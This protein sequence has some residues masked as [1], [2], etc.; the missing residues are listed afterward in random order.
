MKIAISGKRDI[1]EE[2]RWVIGKTLTEILTSRNDVEAIIFGGARGTDTVALECAYKI[3]QEL[4]MTFELVVVV[5]FK[6]DKQPR[7]AR[8]AIERYADRVIELNLPLSKGGY[9]KRNEEIVKMADLIIAFW[10][11]KDGGTWHTIKTAR[12]F[13]KE[14]KI[15]DVL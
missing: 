14:I 6:V 2:A 11:R 4:N 9:F 13:G 5:P 7:E 8:E 12:K 10:D 15:V 1:S 3:K